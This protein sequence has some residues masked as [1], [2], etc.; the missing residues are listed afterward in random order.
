MPV[1]LAGE[2]RCRFVDFNVDPLGAQG[3]SRRQAADPA[4][5]PP[6]P[7]SSRP[8]AT[9]SIAASAAASFAPTSATL[10][11]DIIDKWS[12]PTS[13]TVRLRGKRRPQP[14]VGL[15]NMRPDDAMGARGL[16]RELSDRSQQYDI[17]IQRFVAIVQRCLELA[18]NIS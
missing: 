11:S 12:P 2:L 6:R 14:F 13:M 9:S 16:W 1:P 4:R 3:D 10:G 15:S 8:S 7:R 5:P 17:T 18:R